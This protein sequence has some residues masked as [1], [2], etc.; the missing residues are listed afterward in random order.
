[1][2]LQRQRLMQ[3]HIP[4]RRPCVARDPDEIG[5]EEVEGTRYQQYERAAFHFDV[6]LIVAETGANTLDRSV[7]F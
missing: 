3:R 6:T 5:G 4:E 7:S 2:D 1:M